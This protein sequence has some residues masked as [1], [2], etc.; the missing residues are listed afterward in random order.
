MTKTLA[1]SLLLLFL[2]LATPARAQNINPPDFCPQAAVLVRYFADARDQG[3]LEV[4]ALLH[5][6]YLPYDATGIAAVRSAVKEA[7]RFIAR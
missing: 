2:A 3:E 5:V 1:A 4:S 6:D 7:R